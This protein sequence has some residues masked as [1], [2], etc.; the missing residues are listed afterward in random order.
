MNAKH[1]RCLGM[2]FMRGRASITEAKH[3][4]VPEFTAFHSLNQDPDVLYSLVLNQ[5]ESTSVMNMAKHLE[6]E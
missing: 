4:K 3:P 6:L 1:S 5:P 2:I